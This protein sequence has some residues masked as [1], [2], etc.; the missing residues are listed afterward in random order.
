M[1]LFGPNMISLQTSELPLRQAGYQVESVSTIKQLL[2]RLE[3]HPCRYA[4]ILLN[5]T[6]SAEL[7]AE[8]CVLASRIGIPT[9]QI[10]KP[11]QTDDSVRDIAKMWRQL[12][13][14][15]AQKLH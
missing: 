14:C 10:R 8:A 2:E 3:R 13:A 11:P 15:T 6:L 4:M 9:H 1:G 7:Q 5:H 12:S